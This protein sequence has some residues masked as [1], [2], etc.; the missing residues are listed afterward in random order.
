MNETNNDRIEDILQIALIH[1]FTFPSWMQ[2]G[3]GSVMLWKKSGNENEIRKMQLQADKIKMGSET[4]ANHFLAI[5]V[6]Q[7]RIH[8]QCT[9]YFIWTYAFIFICILI[10]IFVSLLLVVLFCSFLDCNWALASFVANVFTNAIHR[11]YP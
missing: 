11:Y 7:I 9:Y 3:L 6:Q 5:I 10:F 2:L 8:V 4:G 1:L